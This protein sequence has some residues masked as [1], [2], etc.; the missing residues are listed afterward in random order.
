[1]TLLF[2]KYFNENI[3][4][5]FCVFRSHLLCFNH[6]HTR[7]LSVSRKIPP[8]GS[9]SLPDVSKHH[10]PLV[11]LSKRSGSGG[12]GKSVSQP[13]AGV[14]LGSNG[15]DLE[16]PVEIYPGFAFIGRN[17]SPG[18]CQCEKDEWKA[19]QKEGIW[20][21][22]M[23]PYEERYVDVKFDGKVSGL[24]SVA[25]VEDFQGWRLFLLASGFVMLLLAP[26]VSRNEI[27]AN[28]KEKYFLFVCI[29]ISGCFL[30]H[31]FSMLVHS[32]LENFGPRVEMHTSVSI[33]LLLLII[34][35]GAALGFWAVRKFAISEDGTVDVQFVKWSMQIMATTVIFQVCYHNFPGMLSHWYAHEG[36]NGARRPTL[37]QYHA[38]AHVSVCNWRGI[39]WGA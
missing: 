25:V 11:D 18:L 24:V 6:H 13:S 34:F 12:G 30:L 17:A 26:N 38:S 29:R 31:H 28:W 23:S 3:Q 16:N 21:Y 2:S 32:L 39:A 27:V 5:Y 4:K 1:M 8:T 22:I 20:N 10:N 7:I 15:V 37:R 33:L 14:Y 35:T 9:P 36:K 19:I